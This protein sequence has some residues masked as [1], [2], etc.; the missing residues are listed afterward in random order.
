MHGIMLFFPL[1]APYSATYLLVPHVPYRPP[2]GCDDAD[3]EQYMCDKEH[4]G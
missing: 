1:S 3:G 4:V 2:R